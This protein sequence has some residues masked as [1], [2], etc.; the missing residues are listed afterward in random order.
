[1]KVALAS[2]CFQKGDVE[3][4]L[5]AHLD[6]LTTF[7]DAGCNLAV[8]PEMSLTGYI[9]PANRAHR[10]LS[11][12]PIAPEIDRIIRASRDLDIGVLF[13]IAETNDHGKP[14]IAQIYAANGVVAGVYRKRHLGE[15]EDEF[16][17]GSDSFVG[18]FRGLRFGVAICADMDADDEFS[19]AGQRGADVVFHPS[20]PGLYGER[21][22]DDASWQRGLD[23]WRG[24]CIAAHG[25]RARRLGLPIAV[26]TH[27]GATFDE[28]FPG[29]AALFDATGEIVDELP[30][31]QAESLYIDL[32][33]GL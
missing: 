6:A 19:Y 25:K 31:W 17:S 30:D 21:R 10:T 4:N 18:E 11:V 20:A 12:D 23:W 13:G 8:F 32:E 24:A 1:M 3:G 9:D 27:S 16:A 28:D 5:A 2:L 7:A 14:F 22:K 15:D 26:A 33:K 29:W